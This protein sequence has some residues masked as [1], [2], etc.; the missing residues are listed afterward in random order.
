M[1]NSIQVD[2]PNTPKKAWHNN[3]PINLLCPLCSNSKIFRSPKNLH[4]HIH[5]KH[6]EFDNHKITKKQALKL[7]DSIAKAESLGMMLK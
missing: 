1:S 4:H 7:L 2:I 6:D 5:Q 3:S